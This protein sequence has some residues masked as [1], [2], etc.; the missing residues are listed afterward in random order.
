MLERFG[1]RDATD[2][3]RFVPELPKQG[4]ADKEQDG[5]SAENPP[6]D[7]DQR[8]EDSAAPVRSYYYD[9]AYGYQDYVPET[10]AE[11]KEEGDEL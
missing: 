9:D 1:D 10:D 6:E 11:E 8:P 2:Y 3:K 5:S 4:E 7:G